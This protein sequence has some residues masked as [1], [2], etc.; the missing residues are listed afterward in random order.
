MKKILLIILILLPAVLY[1][2]AEKWITIPK[3]ESVNPYEKLW[4]ATINVELGDKPDTTINRDE[5][6][7]GP[8]QIRKVRIDDY[9]K[10]TGSHYS[11]EDCLDRETARKIYMYYASKYG[12]MDLENIARAWNGGPDGMKKEST[13]KYFRAIQKKLIK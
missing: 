2:P 4:Q 1:A 9:N 7:Y 13:V 5:W 11:L 6:A 10:R 3:A 8:G 12:P